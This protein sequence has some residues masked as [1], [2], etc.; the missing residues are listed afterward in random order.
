MSRRRTIPPAL[1]CLT[2]LTASAAGPTTAPTVA[3]TVAPT[4]SSTTGPTTAP[5]AATLDPRIGRWYA[6]LGD[7]DPAVRDDAAEQLMGLGESGDL[8]AL[9]AVVRAAA[10]PASPGAVVALHEVVCQDYLVL[11]DPYVAVGEA[12]DPGPHAGRSYVMGLNWPKDLPDSAR[13]G[14]PVADRWVGFPARRLLRDG[15]LILGVYLNPD[16]PLL[17]LPNLFTHKPE[18]LVGVM[19]RLPPGQRAVTLA[20]LRDGHERTVRLPLAPRP[21][22]GTGTAP[23]ALD[24]F[25]AERRQRAEAYWQR[26][27]APA[28]DPSAD[29]GDDGQP[30]A[31]VPAPAATP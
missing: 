24:A 12:G 22:E 8:D 6:A 31:A 30:D 10:R 4:A 25:L 2:L 27:F 21:I 1:A 20:I 28:V 17:E 23:M 26:A 14:V 13:V 5:A 18:D 9:L 7:A 19:Q 29:D 11:R 3:P 16:R 15:D